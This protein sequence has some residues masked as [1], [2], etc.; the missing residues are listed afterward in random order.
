LA[1][2][3][4][5]L[6]NITAFVLLVAV[7]VLS[8]SIWLRW[9]GEF[10][11]KADPPFQ[12][13][14]VIVLA[15]DWYGDRVLRG[16]ELVKQ[17]FAPIAF[18]SGPDYLYGVN[19]GELGVEF[20]VKQGYPR[21]YFQVMTSSSFSTRDEAAF[22]AHWLRA[23]NVHKVMIVTNDFHTRRAGKFFRAAL[24][25]DVEVRMIAVPDRFFTP[26]AWWHNREGQKVFFFEWSKTI[27]EVFG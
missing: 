26:N 25:S 6:R 18:I 4:S 9:L 7:L 2:R 21:E 19:E 1:H 17:G 27:A 3:K 13:G 11:V 8:H 12:A 23:R 16:G 5:F 24:G 20:A 22:S 10:L 15:G 14:A